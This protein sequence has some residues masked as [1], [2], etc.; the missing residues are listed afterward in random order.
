M[1][2]LSLALLKTPKLTYLIRRVFTERLLISR[3][4]A[5]FCNK[6]TEQMSNIRFRIINFYY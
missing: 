4:V 1:Q 6:K 5:L 3:S 2:V